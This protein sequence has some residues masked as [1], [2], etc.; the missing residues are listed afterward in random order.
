VFTKCNCL[1][2]IICFDCCHVPCSLITSE[3]TSAALNLQEPYY[4]QNCLSKILPFPSVP[5]IQFTF[6]RL[7]HIYSCNLSNPDT[8]VTP[9]VHNPYFSTSDINQMLTKATTNFSFFHLNIHSLA[10][11]FYKLQDFVSIL[12]KAPNCIAISETWLNS[13]SAI[14]SV[15][16]KV[17]KRVSWWSFRVSIPFSILRLI[18][19]TD[20]HKNA[21]FHPNM[22]NYLNTTFSFGKQTKH[23]F[24]NKVHCRPTHSFIYVTAFSLG[25]VAGATALRGPDIPHNLTINSNL[26]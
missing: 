25:R 15:S 6:S 7:D 23:N 3:Q 22:L 2:C 12:D 17:F 5:D 1:T 13:G 4:C 11:N 26:R 16:F 9:N 19:L 8:Y 10:K 21:S 14:G 20:F 24:I 18:L